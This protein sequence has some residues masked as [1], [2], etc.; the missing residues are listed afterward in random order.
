MSV[1][2]HNPSSQ[3]LNAP[4]VHDNKIPMTQQKEPWL[5]VNLSKLLPGLGEIYAGN[6]IQGLCT[7]SLLIFCIL[8][9]IYIIISPAGNPFAALLLYLLTVPLAIWS[10]FNAH[11]CARVQNSPELQQLRKQQ[12]DPWL[13]VFLSQFIPGLGHLYFKQWIPGILLL[14][15]TGVIIVAAA[16]VAMVLGDGVSDLIIGVWFGFIAYQTYVSAPNRAGRAMHAILPLTAAIVAFILLWPNFKML[17][18][19]VFEARYIPSG[20]MEPALQINDRLIINKLEYRFQE[21]QRGDIILFN[22]TPALQQLVSVDRKLP[23]K[24]GRVRVRT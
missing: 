13:G 10:L 2:L 16:S 1:N 4:S 20:A 14:L 23:Q 5:A 15:L 22:P 17:R 11:R 18:T 19:Y 7:A 6:V 12:A 21:P 8:L 24:R 9:S 3:F